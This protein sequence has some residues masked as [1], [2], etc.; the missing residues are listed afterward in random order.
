MSKED[1]IKELKRAEHKAR[2]YPKSGTVRRN[3]KKII[4]EY[5]APE[6]GKR[7][8]VEESTYADLP[9][10][11]DVKPGE[12]VQLQEPQF[13]TVSEENDS[14]IHAQG[15]QVTKK[16]VIEKYKATRLQQNTDHA[17]LPAQTETAV[18]SLSFDN[19][20][21]EE[22]DD[23]KVEKSK[24]TIKKIIKKYR[25]LDQNMD[26]ESL[27]VVDNMTDDV[28][29]QRKKS[30][31]K[32]R[33]AKQ[34]LKTKVLEQATEDLQTIREPQE[35]PVPT[36]N[37]HIQKEKI[38][39][40]DDN[41]IKKG[42]NK[43]ISDKASVLDN[44]VTASDGN[45]DDSE[46][47]TTENEP[48]S[49]ASKHKI[50]KAGKKVVK[51]TD[52]GSNAAEMNAAEEFQETPLPS[53]DTPTS[54]TRRKSDER[55]NKEKL[56]DSDGIQHTHVPSEHISN[57]DDTDKLN[58]ADA[59]EQENETP[60]FDNRDAVSESKIQETSAEEIIPVKNDIEM[61][62]GETVSDVINPDT[63]AEYHVHHPERSVEE[64]N[65]PTKETIIDAIHPEKMS[66]GVS[67]GSEGLSPTQ[68]STVSDD[69]NKPMSESSEDK[70]SKQ[71]PASQNT[72]TIQPV[73]Q[74]ERR[75]E[76][77][78]TVEYDDLATRKL[79]EEVVQI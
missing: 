74:D 2:I 52:E 9:S 54:K 10:G 59:N 69:K 45:L 11:E 33:S 66:F 39:V 26:E 67:M 41:K 7:V 73:L 20:T 22:H 13:P 56:K 1:L 51:E 72:E 28:T 70:I 25:M 27:M 16:P 47:G 60:L 53:V 77:D 49:Q 37:Q 29:E 57:A 75:I 46:N 14:E 19:L 61:Q 34:I 31:Q 42:T 4:R 50:R 35:M 24:E 38:E 36:E 64:I 3:I 43:I 71:K 63:H 68:M 48:P 17:A 18:S 21:N 44:D 58:A 55:T 40:K 76:N 62:H 12:N 78:K 23:T 6:D 30:T 15:E 5:R 65:K 79:G 32:I 8:K